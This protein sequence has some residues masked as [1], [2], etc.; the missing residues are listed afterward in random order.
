MPFNIGVAE[1][2]SDA[3]YNV[4]FVIDLSGTVNYP[5]RPNSDQTVL[6][7]EKSFLISIIRSLNIEDEVSIIGFVSRPHCVPQELHC[8]LNPISFLP[9]IEDSIRT[10]AVPAEDSGTNIALALNRARSVLEKAK[11]SKNVVLLT[12]GIDTNEYGIMQTVQ[13]MSSFGV[14]LYTIGVGQFVNGALL[15]NMADKSGGL[16]FEPDE[17]DKLKI[18]F[19]GDEEEQKCLKA[20]S[21]RAVLMDTAHWITKGD[22]TLSANV[23]GYNLVVP[24]LWGRKLVATDC[25]RTLITAGRYGLGR[26]AVMSTDD[27]GKWSGQL[28]S[29]DNSKVI[30]KMV[31]WAIGDFTK[32]IEFDVRVKD[33]TLGKATDVNVISNEKPEEKG[34]DFVKIDA[35]LYSAK[36]RPEKVGFYQLL[37]A[38]VGV[39]YND[40]YEKIGLN[41]ALGELVTISGGKVFEPNDVEKIKDTIITMSKRVKIKTVNYRWPFVIAALILFLIE[42]FIR[43]L[44]QN[45]DM[46]N[47]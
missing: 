19:M 18:I 2:K 25:D 28:F 8:V 21:G 29:R 30:T 5:F 4:V 3:K 22:L 41:P 42:V 31:N 33:T 26:V 16:Y 1:R 38:S 24:E 13:S 46:S 47:F 12:D 23:G 39:S 9:N 34:L 37:G 27:G 43:R 35:G 10:F 6:D 11:G 17:S 7:F 20:T 15:K 36:F 32:D 40:E 44:R 45:K 14:K